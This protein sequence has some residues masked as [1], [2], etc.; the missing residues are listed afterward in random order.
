MSENFFQEDSTPAEIKI[1][2]AQTASKP[3]EIKLEQVKTELKEL[4]DPEILDEKKL[5]NPEILDEKK[6]NDENVDMLARFIDY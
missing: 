6:S 4:S 1:Y 5:S 2:P 3:P